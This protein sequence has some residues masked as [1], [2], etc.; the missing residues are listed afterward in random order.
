MIYVILVFNP[1]VDSVIH[2]FI[3]IIC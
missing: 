2:I 1:L 3:D